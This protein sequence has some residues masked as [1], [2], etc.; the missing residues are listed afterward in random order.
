[1]LLEKTQ[2]ASVTGD[3][4]EYNPPPYTAEFP[5]KEQLESV[6][7]LVMQSIPP[8]TPPAVLLEKVTW[9]SAGEELPLQH[10]PPPS[11]TAELLK[12]VQLMILGEE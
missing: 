7:E 4:D 9:S 6:G 11:C 1:V 8:P 3:W 10:I 12:K 5:E 2:L